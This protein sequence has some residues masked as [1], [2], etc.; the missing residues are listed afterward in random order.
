MSEEE[1]QERVFTI[2]TLCELGYEF[3][4]QIQSQEGKKTGIE[5]TPN[6]NTKQAA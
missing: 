1:L 2:Q 3:L 5:I 4:Q 6:F